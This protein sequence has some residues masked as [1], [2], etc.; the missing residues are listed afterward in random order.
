M[1]DLI[2]PFFDRL[3]RVG[4]PVLTDISGAARREVAGADLNDRL[5]RLAGMLAEAGARPGAPVVAL[6][7]NTLESALT[8]LAA[9]RHGFTLAL[10]PAGTDVEDLN[11]LQGEIGARALVNATP[12]PVEGATR[13]RL[14]DLSARTPVAPSPVPPGTPFTITF[15][16]GSTGAPKGIVHGAESFLACGE[17]FNRQ[18]GITGHDRF[19]NVMPMFYMAG[20]FNGILAPLMAG[21]PVVIAEGFNTVTAM[22]FWPTLAAE[23]ITALW[24]S[25]TMLSLV[26]RLDRTAKRVPPAMRRLFVG[27]GA[28]A[29][30]DAEQ[31]HRTY[32]LPPLQSYGLSELLYVSVD[33]AEAPNFGTAGYP[34][35]GVALTGGADAPLSITSPY[36]FLGYLVD[37]VLQAH[38]GPFLTS[39]LAQ[40]DESGRLSILGRA[41]DIIL[42]GGVNVNPVDIEA[43]LSPFMRGRA[44]CVTG[45]R[46]ATLGQKVV[47]VTEGAGLDDA[48]FAEAQKIVRSHPGRAQLDAAAQVT[49]LPV[50]PTGKIRRA[51]LR[52]QLEGGGA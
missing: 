27:T 23:R 33:S 7:D 46:D 9:M 48:A 21:A 35:D 20:I 43:A 26:S 11:R 14:E 1:S 50:G 12:Q 52:A 13:I 42:R 34:L 47:L 31:F 19:L 4:G 29:A 10:Q 39:D 37:G 16:S 41:D 22:R 5:D 32:G 51:A 38:D 8:L 40:V 15:T 45:L 3:S 30:S 36:G 28:M 49:K 18:T 24:L 17:A 2:A 6:F 25:P 44:Y